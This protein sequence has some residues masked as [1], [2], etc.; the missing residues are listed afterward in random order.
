MQASVDLRGSS[1]RGVPPGEGG[2]LGSAPRVLRLAFE[3]A[4]R[5]SRLVMSVRSLRSDRG[6]CSSCARLQSAVHSA[7]A[8]RCVLPACLVFL[9]T[10]VVQSTRLAMR[11]SSHGVLKDHPS[12]DMHSRCP[13]PRAARDALR[14]RPCQ[15]LDVFRPC[16]FSRLRRLSPPGWC[17]LVAS[18]C[19]SWDSSGFRLCSCRGPVQTPRCLFTPML[20]TRPSWSRSCLA[21]RPTTSP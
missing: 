7:E 9:P 3:D 11:A 15:I 5:H 19:Q 17:G 2:H 14:S 8:V 21:P 12:I 4:L 10:E 18:R 1:S 20:R 6:R 16:R 13:L